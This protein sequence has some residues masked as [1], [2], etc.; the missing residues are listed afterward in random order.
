MTGMKLGPSAPRYVV[1][2]T[3]FYQLESKYLDHRAI[4]IAFGQSF[5]LTNLPANGFAF[6]YLIHPRSI[7]MIQRKRLVRYLG[8][9]LHHF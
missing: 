1:E 2:P 3:S 5:N 7:V 9:W 8:S 4:L 6:P